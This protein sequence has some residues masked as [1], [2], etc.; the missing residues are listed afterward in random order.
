MNMSSIDPGRKILMYIWVSPGHLLVS[1]HPLYNYHNTG[2]LNAAKFSFM[3][4]VLQLTDGT[5]RHLLI[6]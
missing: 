4:L 1:F 3:L 2:L 5:E 6:D